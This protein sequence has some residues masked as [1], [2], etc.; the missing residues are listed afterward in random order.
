MRIPAVLARRRRGGAAAAELLV[1]AS[2]ADPL[3]TYRQI[4]V[5]ALAWE[6][7]PDTLNWAVPLLGMTLAA[8]IPLR[9]G[10]VNLGGDGQLVIG[11]LVAALVPLALPGPGWIA[12][13]LAVLLAML[14]AGAYAA[15]AAW[16]EARHGVPTA[17]LQ[18]AAELSGDR[19][20]L[21][22]GRLP[23]ARHDRA[24]CRRRR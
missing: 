7:L 10:M 6:N 18:P 8:A 5:G 17:D 22:P 14:A 23:A 24:G 12:M 15:L 11:G 3:A 4:I 19:A 21:L 1:L 2:G 20:R 13:I 16:G 9:G